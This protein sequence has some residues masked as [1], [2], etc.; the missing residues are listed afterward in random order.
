MS[1]KS[2]ETSP[3]C[4]FLFMD[5]PKLSLQIP[6]YHRVI[7]RWFGQIILSILRWNVSGPIPDIPKFVAIAAPHTSNWDFVVGMAALMAL[8]IK[9]CWLGKDTIFRWPFGTLWEK[10]GGT[11]VDRFHPNGVVGQCIDLFG[12]HEQ[13][14]LGLSPEGTRKKTERW[15]TGFYYIAI[16]ANVPILLVAFDYP[17]RI[18]HIGE[19]FYPTG[20][21]DNDIHFMHDYFLNFKGKYPDQY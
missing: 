8:D 5:L 4:Q 7:V 21:A 19:L 14:I 3:V 16:G 9:V 2:I 20:N 12:R 18:L 17:T 15:R 11:P 13:F 6:R 10:L 1:G